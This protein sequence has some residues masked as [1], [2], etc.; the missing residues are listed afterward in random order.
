[1]DGSRV[2]FGNSRQEQVSDLL[3]DLKLAREKTGM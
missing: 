3:A 1:M 2:F